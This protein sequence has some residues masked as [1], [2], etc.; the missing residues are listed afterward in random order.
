MEIAAA[1]R[2]ARNVSDGKVIAVVQPHRYSRLRDL[3]DDFCGCLNEADMAIVTDVFAA[4]ESPIDGIDRDGLVAGLT[5]H[6]HQNAIALSSFGDLPRVISA[7]AE[8][9]DYVVL[10]GAGDITNHAN[11]LEAKLA[12]HG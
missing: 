9:G 12:D 10:L 11:A 6:G 1:L 3:F 5:A 2:A 8:P 7:A 4:G